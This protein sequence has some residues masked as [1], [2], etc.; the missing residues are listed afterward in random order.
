MI[1]MLTSALVGWW[2]GGSVGEDG[3]GENPIIEGIQT[4]IG[5]VFGLII[6][7]II[8]FALFLYLDVG[9]QVIKPLFET[10]RSY[11][12]AL[13]AAIEKIPSLVGL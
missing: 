8:G 3:E 6:I 2:A 10:I 12:G 9:G 5:S 11:I 7:L 13:V 4:L 1:T